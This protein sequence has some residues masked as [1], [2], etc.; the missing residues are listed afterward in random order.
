MDE[1]M[2]YMKRYGRR[3]RAGLGDLPGTIGT[4][5]DV[6]A[7]PYLPEVVCRIGQLKSIDRHEPVGLCVNTAEGVVTGGV[8][9]RNVIP[10][11]RAYVYAQQNPWIYP[12]AAAAIVVVPLWIGYLLG[13][14]PR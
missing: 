11:L 9:I 14:G 5:L 10:V 13:K 12:V 3:S 8:G 4:V 2:S 6:A 7:D 1:T